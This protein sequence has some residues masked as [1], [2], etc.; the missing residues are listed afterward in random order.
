MASHIESPY[1]IYKRDNRGAIWS[2]LLTTGHT[3]AHVNFLTRLKGR[4]DRLALLLPHN[5]SYD[6]LASCGG[7]KDP[8]E[9]VIGT[10]VR[11]T[12]E[13]SH[14]CIISQSELAGRLKNDSFLITR[15]VAGKQY[16]TAYLNISDMHPDGFPLE[17]AQEMMVYHSRGKYLD[18]GSAEND[19]L[20][21]VWWDELHAVDHG[22]VEKLPMKDV[23]GNDVF[24]R[25]I[26]LPSY[27]F[28]KSM[29]DAGEL[30]LE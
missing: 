8:G 10:Q 18:E 3:A 24:I 7:F 21:A 1:T 6:V 25:A 12:G 19:S 23:D 5:K 13:E 30:S 15:T 28:V 14:W 29:V 9:T 2:L 26:V 11:E 16:F 17:A 4:G 27:R 22:K 20:H